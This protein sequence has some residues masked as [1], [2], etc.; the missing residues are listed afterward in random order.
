MHHLEQ[1]VT[2]WRRSLGSQNHS[3]NIRKCEA[4]VGRGDGK[5]SNLKPFFKGDYTGLP[6]EGSVWL[7]VQENK[8]QVKKESKAFRSFLQ[9]HCTV[10]D[11]G[12]GLIMYAKISVT[13]SSL[14]AETKSFF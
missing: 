11:S 7:P 14:F 9:V 12:F 1:N 4:M 10:T 8:V 13:L 2:T 5:G 3:N 6:L